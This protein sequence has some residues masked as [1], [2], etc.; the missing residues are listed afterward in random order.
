MNTRDRLIVALDVDSPE[1]AI[2]LTKL[3][4]PYVGAFKVGM[5]LFN[6]VG[7]EIIYTLKKLGANIFVD[8]KLHD[9]PNTV[10]RASRVLT[11]HGADILNVHAAGGKEMMQ[12]AAQA[13]NKEVLDKGLTRPLV[14]AVTVLTSISARA[15]KEEIGFAGEIE[16]KVVNWAKLAQAA[17]LDGVVA[18]PQEIRA[19]RQACGP[20]FVIITPGIR[21]SGGAVHDQKRVTTPG[22][23][24]AAGAT[25]IVV[26]RPITENSDPVQAARNIV[27][28]MN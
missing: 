23:A 9:I 11:S 22:E 8:L 10:A 1:K 18:S 13:V 16:D 26:G 15:F 7:P 24:I 28:E 6:S 2:H 20:E 25:Y 12:S 27:S 3:L 5:E 14:V 21:P 4:S 19:I 17:G